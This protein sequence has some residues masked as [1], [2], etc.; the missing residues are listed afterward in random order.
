MPAK[1]GR[2][3]SK[4]SPRALATARKRAEAVNLRIQGYL[5]H[6]IAETLKVSTARAYQLCEEAWTETIQEPIERVRAIAVARCDALLTGFM[7]SAMDGD[8][9]ALEAVMKIEERRDRLMGLALMVKHEH[10]HEGNIGIAGAVKHEFEVT[11]VKA[12]PVVEEPKTIEA[13]VVNGKG[14]GH[15]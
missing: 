10:Q 15:G 8:H 6:E 12:A 2:K 5:F 3:Q 11:F 4:T 1:K 13:T 7:S 14:N 9:A